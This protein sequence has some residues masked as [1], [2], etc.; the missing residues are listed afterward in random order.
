MFYYIIILMEYVMRTNEM[1]EKRISYEKM[2]AEIS[3]LAVRVQ[4]MNA[5]LRQ[6]L[7]RMGET[8]NVSRVFMFSYESH[9]HTFVCRCGWDDP[10]LDLRSIQ[11]ISSFI[12]LMWL[13]R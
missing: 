10:T 5:F 3:E 7:Q 13:G 1:L 8:L 4:D 11:R 9:N 12:S 2:L 6:A